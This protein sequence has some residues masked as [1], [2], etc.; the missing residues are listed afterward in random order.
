L[1]AGVRANERV[2]VAHR[3]RLRA[4]HPSS[5]RFATPCA[6]SSA[7]SIDARAQARAA[8]TVRLNASAPAIEAGM[9][10]R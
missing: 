6:Y 2:A 7:W 5:V 9:A 4:A 10:I 8:W 3:R 1:P